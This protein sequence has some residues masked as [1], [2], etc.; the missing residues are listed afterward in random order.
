M[1]H[2]LTGAHPDQDDPRSTL[3]AYVYFYD[4]RGGGIE[5]DL[6]QDKQGLGLTKRNKKSFPSQQML[7]QLNALAHNLLVWSRDWLTQR[8]QS[9]AKLG[10]LRLVRDVLCF[11]GVVF[12]I[13]TRPWLRSS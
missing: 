13:L 3:L 11:N 8:C 10:L 2:Q 4:Q 12:L 6:K 5:I 1:S 9:V 7:T